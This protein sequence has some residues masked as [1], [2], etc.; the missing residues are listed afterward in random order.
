VHE[1]VRVSASTPATYSFCPDPSGG[2]LIDP[3]IDP[4]GDPSPHTQSAVAAAAPR[5]LRRSTTHTPL[6]PRSRSIRSVEWRSVEWPS[7]VN[8]RTTV[9]T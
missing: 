3:L 2:P 6:M 4:L 9:R 5:S 7:S 1:E 8:P